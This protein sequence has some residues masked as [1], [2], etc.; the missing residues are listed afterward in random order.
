[1]VSGS[2]MDPDSFELLAFRIRMW[3]RIQIMEDEY[4]LI[5]KIQFQYSSKAKKHLSYTHLDFFKDKK[6]R[7]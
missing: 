4:S 3:I 6:T 5:I 7:E 1:M 2:A